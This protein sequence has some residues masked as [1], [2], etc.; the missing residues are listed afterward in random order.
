MSSV[1]LM[2]KELDFLDKEVTSSIVHHDW[3]HEVFPED[4]REIYDPEEV[5]INRYESI[6]ALVGKVL[7]EQCVASPSFNSPSSFAGFV[8]FLDLA[9]RLGAE[10]FGFYLPYHKFYQSNRWGIYLMKEPI[11]EHSN[12]LYHS[13]EEYLGTELLSLEEVQRI[14]IYC[15]FRHETFH[16][17]VETF[18]TRM[19]LIQNRALYL[20]F[21]Y[22]VE[23]QVINS[24]HWLEEALA[25]STV[26]R[27]RYV[28]NKNK[29]VKAKHITAMYEWHLNLM[30]PGY[31]DYE[32]LEYG[33]P[34]EA[35]K[36]FVSQLKEVKRTPQAILP[37]SLT[38]KSLNLH[39]FS[40]V[41]TYWVSSN[42]MKQIY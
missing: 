21:Q 26:V 1:E 31:S 42:R 25:E 22:D 3:T 29:G 34:D 5:T 17:Q 30:P 36:Y 27:S 24:K 4:L 13:Q 32:C 11:L 12:Y 14:F 10:A 9:K 2:T 20:P 33:G 8:N 28:A 38:V 41:P 7:N 23:P 6:D 40:S 35:H 19:E 39:D 16:Y 15:V 18:A 37:K